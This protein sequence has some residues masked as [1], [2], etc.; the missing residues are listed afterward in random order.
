[1]YRTFTLLMGVPS[2]RGLKRDPISEYDI[3]PWM[4]VGDSTEDFGG[5]LPQRPACLLESSSSPRRR[6]VEAP[7]STFDNFRARP[8]EAFVLHSVQRRVQ[9]AGA[10]AVTVSGQLFRDPCSVDLVIRRVVQHMEL[11]GTAVERAHGVRL[12]ASGRNARRRR[13]D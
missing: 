10:D 11:D 5:E 8:Q 13:D 6:R 1:M 7:F 9:G 4:V 2:I 12:R 3:N